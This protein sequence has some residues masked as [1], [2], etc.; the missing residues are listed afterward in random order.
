MLTQISLYQSLE[1]KKMRGL[2]AG[3]VD[4]KPR[5]RVLRRPPVAVVRGV[6]DLL[7]QEGARHFFAS[8]RCLLRNFQRLIS[9][10]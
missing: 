7:H 1:R 8:L 4:G 9:A 2:T 3:V 5:G 6:L 10:Q